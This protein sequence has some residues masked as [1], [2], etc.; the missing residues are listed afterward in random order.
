MRH[1]IQGEPPPS[2]CLRQNAKSPCLLNIE[3]AEQSRQ[4]KKTIEKQPDVGIVE[5][6]IRPLRV[7]P[8]RRTDQAQLLSCLVRRNTKQ[9]ISP[10]DENMAVAKMA[11][12][13][14][15]YVSAVRNIHEIRQFPRAMRRI[16]L[17]PI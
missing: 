4:L 3:I 7:D 9:L 12:R 13:S 11:M 16:R 10:L 5:E 8:K 1:N 2:I 14:A 17:I 6:L 15:F